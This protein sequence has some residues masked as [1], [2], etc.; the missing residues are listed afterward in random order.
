MFIVRF[1]IEK[2]IRILI[3]YALKLEAEADKVTDEIGDVVK[4]Y[5]DLRNK[6]VNRLRDKRLKL[7]QLRDMVASYI[8]LEN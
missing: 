2:V 8:N 4:R 3:N 6:A 7:A 5:D 1:I